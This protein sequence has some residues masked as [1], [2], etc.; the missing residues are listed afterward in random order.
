[1]LSTYAQA[2]LAVDGDAEGQLDELTRFLARWYPEVMAPYRGVYWEMHDFPAN[3]L[4]G[5][6][7]SPHMPVEGPRASARF[8][9]LRMTIAHD[10]VF[11]VAACIRRHRPDLRWMLNIARGGRSAKFPTFW[12]FQRH[13]INEAGAILRAILGLAETWPGEEIPD[14]L[15]RQG[16]LSASTFA[17][18]YAYGIAHAPSP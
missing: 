12:D 11:I 4:V 3:R 8:E 7:V 1:M 15:A 2:G 10:A 6:E 17:D 16:H 18:I 13:P 14:H 5:D 9:Q